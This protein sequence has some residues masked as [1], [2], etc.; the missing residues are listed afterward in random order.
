MAMRFSYF[1]AILNVDFH[2]SIVPNVLNLVGWLRTIDKIGL[3]YKILLIGNWK[4]INS[5]CMHT[6]SKYN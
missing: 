2:V 3:T 6:T 5:K 1:I 4:P